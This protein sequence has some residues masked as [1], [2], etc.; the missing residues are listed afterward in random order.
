M[1]D[2]AANELLCFCRQE[3][4]HRYVEN[5]FLKN[6]LPACRRRLS[7]I[8][9]RCKDILGREI[10]VNGKQSWGALVRGVAPINCSF[11]ARL[12]VKVTDAVCCKVDEKDI[13]WLSLFNGA[14][15]HRSISIEAYLELL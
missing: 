12:S 3:S 8:N 4:R 2:L 13:V 5:A 6:R 1:R 11:P 7:V 15:D 14:K 10:A 9:H